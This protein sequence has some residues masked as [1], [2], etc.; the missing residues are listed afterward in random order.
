MSVVGGL[1][2]YEQQKVRLHIAGGL[3]YHSICTQKKITWHVINIKLW[4]VVK[5]TVTAHT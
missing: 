3:S 1:G 4:I 2:V 5:M